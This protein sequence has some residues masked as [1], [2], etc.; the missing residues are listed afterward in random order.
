MFVIAIIATAITYTAFSMEQ[1]TELAETIEAK[2]VVDFQQTTE[3]FEI[4]KVRNDNNQFNMTVTNTGDIPVHLT[5]L[6]VENTTDS[7]WPV[8]KFD[9][10]LAIGPGDTVKNIGQ[11]IGL[12]ALDTQSYYAQLI[13]ERGNQKQMFLNSVGDSP[14][15]LRLTATPAVMPTTFSTT[16]TL[17][18]INT[19]TQQLL[20]LQPT[21][22]AVTTPTC[23][24]CSI[25]VEEQTVMP[26]SFDS[27]APGDTALFEWVYSFDG[28]NGDQV[29]F[30]AG[31]VN[32]VETDTVTV[33]LQT[34]ESALNADVAVESG[35][36]G[37]QTL[38][39]DDILIFHAETTV[40]DSG[41]AYQMYSGSADAGGNGDRIELDLETPHF[42]TNNGTLVN[43]VPAGDWDIAMMLSSEPV[44]GT[45]D[46]NYD[47]IFHF[48]DGDDTNPDNSQGDPNRDLMGCGISTYTKELTYGPDDAKEHVDNNNVNANGNDLELA[49]NG[50]CDKQRITGVRFTSVPINNAETITSAT[51]QFEP[52]NTDSG[53]TNLRIYGELPADDNAD[54]FIDGQ[55]NN[56]SNR[57]LTTAYVDWM[58]VP[59]WT[60]GQEGVNTT[61]PD[62]SPIIQE[63]VNRAGW[64]NGNALSIILYD[65]PTSPSS[66]QRKANSEDSN[67]NPAPT[68]VIT[69]GSGNV[70]DWQAGTGPHNSGSYFFDGTDDCF[71]SLNN[72]NAAHGNHIA[73]KNSETS[74]WFKTQDNDLAIAN[75]MYLVDWTDNTG[76]PNCEH[77]RLLLTAG[78]AGPTGGKLQFH[79]SPNNDGESQSVVC[80]STLD[81]DD[82][83]WHHAIIEKDGDTDDCRLTITNTDGDNPEVSIYVDDNV[84]EQNVELN[85]NVRWHVGTNVNE[86]G[87]F[88]KGWI[89]DI[90]HWNNDNCSG[91]CFT[92][93]ER[94]DLAQTN[95]GDGA[96]EFDVWLNVTDANG[97]YVS[98]AY[99]STNVKTAF[100]DPKEG[101]NNDDWAYTQTNMTMNVPELNLLANQRLDL[102]FT[103]KGATSTWQPLEVDMKIDDTSMTDP[104]P[105]FMQIPYP[106]NPFPTYYEHSPQD[107]F[108]IFVSNTGDDGI[109]LTYQGTRVNFNGTGGSYA[110]LIKSANGTLMSED[111]DSKHIPPGDV[112]QLIFNEATDTPAKTE[113]GNLMVDG[114]YSTTIWIVGYSDQ[115]ETFTRSVIVGS[116]EVVTP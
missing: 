62:L 10:D 47:M 104:Y 80:E 103:W 65:H 59:A 90:M 27:L 78:P 93:G 46:T 52:R 87:N 92:A 57:P 30:E 81:Y 6:W 110:G 29:T 33:T 111:Q 12:T 15:F 20:N 31:L 22:V 77:Y 13:S 116:V 14:L 37:D 35:G 83:V 11:N 88:F 53:V 75:D 16:V 82:A 56:I 105:S 40:V 32:D 17:E 3:S 102:Y 54:Q 66:D 114:L 71:R 115:G 97:N 64:S 24:L 8:S 91:S 26:T 45:V 25:P 74:L 95:Y 36:L 89:D 69:Y 23:T 51:L 50:N 5:R 61:T 70:P 67:N 108:K 79:Y 98:S 94:D 44:G 42:F 21:M 19:G 28:E 48:E 73:D 49:C 34:I 99:S 72:V 107:E 96:H 86:N 85:G 100:A 55:A 2:Q 9:L 112:I 4:V 68:L 38:L 76:C 60:A 101:G 1:I 7:S 43:R 58:N 106:D 63:I 109:F 84:N 18:V 39:G 113:V 41:I